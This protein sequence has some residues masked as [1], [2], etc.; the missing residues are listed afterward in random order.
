[1]PRLRK[2]QQHE[3]CM[4]YAQ[5]KTYREIKDYFEEH[6]GFRPYTSQIQ[7]YVRPGV[8][9]QKWLDL[10]QEY[11]D[12]FEV[13][14]MEEELA[15]KRRRLQLLK[16]AHDRAMEWNLEGEAVLVVE[17]PDYDPE[18]PTS[19]LNPKYLKE[20]VAKY[21]SQPAV[22]VAALKQA[23]E[24]VERKE[25]KVKHTGTVE[26]NLKVSEIDEV[27]IEQFDKITNRL[28]GGSGQRNGADTQAEDQ[29]TP[30]E[31]ES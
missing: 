7:N 16:D 18:R 10:I 22:A 20:K 12:K 14:F 24:E 28:L 11:R 4:L 6:Y 23:Q 19:Y 9:K 5:R 27:L 31:P 13:G 8:A 2:S 26:H 25:F 15:S 30:G 29:D 3:L 1:M 17:N 21:K